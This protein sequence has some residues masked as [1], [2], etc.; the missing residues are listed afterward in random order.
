MAGIKR[1]QCD[2]PVGLK[3]A[4]VNGLM[5]GKV[6]E[7]TADSRGINPLTMGVFRSYGAAQTQVDGGQGS[8]DSYAVY[9]GSRCV[10]LA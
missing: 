1:I 7:W 3:A 9:V 2:A 5:G 8:P 4:G 10:S 6:W